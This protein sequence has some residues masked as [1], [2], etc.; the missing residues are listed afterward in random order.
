MGLKSFKRAGKAIATGGGSEIYDLLKGPSASSI[1]K[2]KAM[3]EAA[4]LARL[5][6]QEKKRREDARFATSEGEGIAAA[7]NIDLSIEDT[8]DFESRGI[9]DEDEEEGLGLFI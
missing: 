4:E 3:A 1:R 6:A 7:A 2:A 5:K 8:T 9:I